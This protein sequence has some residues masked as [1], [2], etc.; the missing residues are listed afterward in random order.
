MMR[1]REWKRSVPCTSRGND[2]PPYTRFDTRINLRAEAPARVTYSTIPPKSWRCTHRSTVVR[3]DGTGMRLLFS[4][5]D[6]A[7][8]S[9]NGKRRMQLLAI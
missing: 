8:A 4:Q 9:I 5:W 7:I 2:P 6:E 1:V 3:D